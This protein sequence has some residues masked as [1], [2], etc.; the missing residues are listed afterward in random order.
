MC[1]TLILTPPPPPFHR[2]LS[3]T[4]PNSHVFYSN[5]AAARLQMGLY[6]AAASDAEQ[7]VALAPTYTKAMV[8]LGS[9]LEKQER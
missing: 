2:Q 7:A 3:P 5:R 4:G 8:R 6:T 1:L 9:A